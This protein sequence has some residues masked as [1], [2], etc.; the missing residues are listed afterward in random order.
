MKM[1]R[2]EMIE[3]IKKPVYLGDGLYCVYDGY[4][5]VLSA[6]HENGTHYVAIEPDVMRNLDAY[7]ETLKERMTKLKELTNE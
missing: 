5:V 1:T 6:E 4:T 2:Q 3:L 7:R